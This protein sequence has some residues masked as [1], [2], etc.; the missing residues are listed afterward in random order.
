MRKLK[1]SLKYLC[2]FGLSIIRASPGLIF[3]FAVFY[4]E[5]S[6]SPLGS[7]SALLCFRICTYASVYASMYLR[8]Y[9][10]LS[11]FDN[12][13]L[14]AFLCPSNFAY[15]SESLTTSVH[16]RLQR[17]VSVSVPRCPHLGKPR[18][19]LCVSVSA[20]L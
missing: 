17:R 8:L 9:L 13:R 4:Y 11:Y 18:L 20:S 6:E 16:L 15:I 1:E 14:F 12:F 5:T 7:P 3:L 2:L 10:R 19:H